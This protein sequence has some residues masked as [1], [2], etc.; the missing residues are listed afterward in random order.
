MRK[1][2][3]LISLG[4]MVSVTLFGASPARAHSG[5]PP[6]SNDVICTGSDNIVAS[7]FE[8]DGDDFWVYDAEADGRS[9]VV[10]W[11][12]SYGR[13]GS[14]RNSHTY[15]NWHECTYDMFEGDPVGSTSVRWDH[16]TYDEG[17]DDWNYISGT[18]SARIS[19]VIA[20]VG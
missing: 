7:C 12:T 10:V 14:C 4:L 13:T 18:Y 15:G 9:A 3:A 16:Y 2:S 17:T 19:S 1:R 5:G 8:Q 20:T 6:T 11:E